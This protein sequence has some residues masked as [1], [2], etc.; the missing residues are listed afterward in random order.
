MAL[1]ALLKGVNVGGHKTFRPSVLAGELGLD[2]VSIGAAGT[3]V[4]RQ[5]VTRTNLRKE[6]ARRLPFETDVM[7]C[8]GH[9]ILR[10]VTADPFA[11]QP[12]GPTI[13]QFVSLMATRPRR[14]PD[15]PLVLPPK[16]AWSLKV[17][18]IQGPFLLGLCRRDIKAIGYLGQLEKAVGVPV[19]TR[20]WSTILR[21]ARTL[22][23]QGY[24][25]TG[26]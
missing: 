5:P 4:I 15:A 19:T 16:G 13:L 22:E 6:M 3:F 2:V 11:G 21:I 25:R 1:V 26:G 8:E 7:V 24:N 18:A 10:L 20:S 23:G 9:E 17:L 12:S 14:V